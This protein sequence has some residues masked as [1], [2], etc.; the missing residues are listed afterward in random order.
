M[1]DSGPTEALFALVS[2][3]DACDASGLAFG[4]LAG[5]WYDVMAISSSRSSSLAKEMVARELLSDL[6][7]LIDEGGLF[8]GGCMTVISAAV[9][10]RSD[11]LEPESGLRLDSG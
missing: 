8:A 1:K 9:S 4:E 2:S 11:T 7:L 6:V 3:W 10:S 5:G